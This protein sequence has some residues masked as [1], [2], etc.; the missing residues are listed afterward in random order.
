MLQQPEGSAEWS[1][2][3]LSD[4]P[5][6]HDGARSTLVTVLRSNTS[7]PIATRSRSARALSAGCMAGS[8]RSPASIRT[9]RAALVSTCRKSR[10]ME[11]GFY[12]YNRYRTVDGYSIFGARADLKFVG[13]QT[14]RVVM[15]R[16]MEI[17]DIMTANRDKKIWGAAQGKD[18]KNDD[19]NLPPFAS[20]NFPPKAG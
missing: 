7:T 3:I 10:G 13:G 4:S 18:Y 17:L 19:L 12:W 6:A 20:E 15:Q 1:P 2:W 8:R 11:R 14:N 9:T 5:R 16:E